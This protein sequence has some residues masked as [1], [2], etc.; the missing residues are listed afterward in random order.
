MK[1]RYKILILI[2]IAILINYLGPIRL[3][4][5]NNFYFRDT[6]D[7]FFQNWIFW[8]FCIELLILTIILLIV[9]RRNEN[10]FKRLIMS[11]G[12]STFF[13]IISFI[14]VYELSKDVTLLINR[15]SDEKMVERNFTIHYYNENSN[16]LKFKDILSDSV[17]ETFYDF[18]KIDLK[19]I[20]SKDTITLIL[21][22]GNF[23]IEYFDIKDKRLIK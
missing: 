16:D 1:K 6:Y 23:G 20:K 14:V 3:F 2:I 13:T 18:D 9:F 21:G 22:K 4:Q 10:P 11:L 15:K 12:F 17:F 19:K 7:T 5:N 8:I